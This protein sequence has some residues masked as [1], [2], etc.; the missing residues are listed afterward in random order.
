MVPGLA[1]SPPAS[2]ARNS[3]GYGAGKPSRRAEVDEGRQPVRRL[4][5]QARDRRRENL[6]SVHVQTHR[7]HCDEQTRSR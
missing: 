1:A 3:S 7:E 4:P 5:A 2:A 6:N